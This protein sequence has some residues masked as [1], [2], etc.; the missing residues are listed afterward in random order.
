MF[1]R[2]GGVT[3]LSQRADLLVT[4]TGSQTATFNFVLT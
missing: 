3:V 1:S 4:M 2:G